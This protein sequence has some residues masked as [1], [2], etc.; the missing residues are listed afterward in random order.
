MRN[1]IKTTLTHFN[2]NFAG[3]LESLFIAKMGNDSKL[4]VKGLDVFRQSEEVL[5][6][7]DFNQMHSAKVQHSH[8]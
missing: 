7:V 5:F 6:L 3:K 2:P 1:N 8:N 4:V